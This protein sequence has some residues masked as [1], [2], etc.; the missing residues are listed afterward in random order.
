LGGSEVE[1]NTTADGPRGFPVPLLY[2]EIIGG[3]PLRDDLETVVR[4]I[5]WQTI[6][7]QVTGILCVSWQDGIESRDQ[8]N[9]LVAAMVK[10]LPYRDRIAAVLSKDSQRI[11]F[12]REALIAATRVAVTEGSA[13][14]LLSTE[15]R[16]TVL[17]LEKPHDL[18]LSEPNKRIIESEY[19][20]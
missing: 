14:D 8:Q 17:N 5:F 20:R 11:L 9:R 12:T 3:V 15:L 13:A 19:L 7:M 18:L 4:K 16:S 6:V 10:H 1:L 2:S